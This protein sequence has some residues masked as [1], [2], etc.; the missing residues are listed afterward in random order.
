MKVPAEIQDIVDNPQESLHIE[1]KEWVD[2]ATDKIAKAKM[3]RHLAA[4]CN[5]GGGYI[6]FG[7]RDDGSQAPRRT[8]DFTH[9]EHD[10]IGGIIDR[11]LSPTFHCDVFRVYRT[12]GAEVFPVVRVPG[13][14][15]VPICAKQDGPHDRKNN[16]QGIRAGTYY[17]RAP[18]PKSTA[19]ETPSQWHDLIHRCVINE[20][21]RL[22]E[23][24]AKLLG[25]PQTPSEPADDS[26][27][28]WHDESWGNNTRSDRRMNDQSWPVS[29]PDNHYHF[30]YRIIEKG[31]TTE[32]TTTTLAEAIR[33]AGESVRNV[34][35]TGW[36][37]FH[38]F[39]RTEIAPKIV[40]DTSTGEEVEALET[41][42]TGE[43][44]VDTTVPDFWRI[45][46]DGRATIIRPYRE[47]RMVIP[48]LADR[49]LMPGMWL[50]PRTLIRE[51][52]ELVT[53]AKE[54]AKAF[55]NAEF[56]EF[57]CSWHGL[58]DRKIAD[59]EAGTNWR[60]RK[61]HVDQ[62]TTTVTASVE[63]MAA[64]IA[65]VVVKLS[66]PV[67]RLFSGLELGQ[68]WIEKLVPKFRML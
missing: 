5:H 60:D 32:H 29:I 63:Q 66:A 8:V 34:V 11:Y 18:G 64:D 62:R 47:D 50:S 21:E 39:S 43:T 15:P 57:R 48:H 56:V 1:L 27:K 6:L 10:A 25:P 44:L 41:D 46:V 14:G 3:A 58:R 45:T 38:Q 12:A 20:R 9:Y 26:L 30:S 42:L 37:M 55:P 28:N 33:I 51:L 68:D 35:W 23:S 53:H 40:I 16:P 65:S 2:L 59:F 36:S 7:F 54:L 24:L 67:L 31:G 61:C 52:Y 19:I 22:L 49:G 13:H 17:I 4:I